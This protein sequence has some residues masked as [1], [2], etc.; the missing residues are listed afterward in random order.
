M[1]Y[2]SETD[3]DTPQRGDGGRPQV[4]VTPPST[5]RPN[6]NLF[7]SMKLE[8]Q[9]LHEHNGNNQ[10]NEVSTYEVL[11]VKSHAG[12]WDNERQKH[13]GPGVRALCFINHGVTPPGPPGHDKLEVT[14]SANLGAVKPAELLDLLVTGPPCEEP[15]ISSFV[16]KMVKLKAIQ[17][18]QMDHPFPAYLID[19]HPFLGQLG[20]SSKAALTF[21]VP[22]DRL[23]DALEMRH[24]LN[25]PIHFIPFDRVKFEHLQ[26]S[27]TSVESY[28]NTICT[29][30]IPHINSFFDGCGRVSDCIK[31]R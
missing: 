20:Y 30:L 2:V 18:L 7:Q 22:N 12:S 24:Q 16:R 5:R 9:E 14:V 17:D 8:R 25:T 29:L 4:R 6:G 3:P 28:I 11:L 31:N 1:D 19:K 10:L 13:L 21:H 26:D 27:I 15:T 23:Q